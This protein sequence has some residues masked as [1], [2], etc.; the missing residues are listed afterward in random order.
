MAGLINNRVVISTIV[1]KRLSASWEVL[2][3]LR[4]NVDV[5]QDLNHSNEI[6]DIPC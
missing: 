2:G 6:K 1:D 3:F 4:E 5:Y